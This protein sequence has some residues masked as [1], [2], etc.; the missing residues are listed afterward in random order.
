M[1]GMHSKAIEGRSMGAYSVDIPAVAFFILEWTVYSFTLEHTAYGRHS[2]SARMN[3]YREV[4]V[5]RMLDREGINRPFQDKES[6]RW[7]IDRICTH[8]RYLNRFRMHAMQHR[9]RQPPE[10]DEF[11]LKRSAASHFSLSVAGGALAGA[12]SP[13]ARKIASSL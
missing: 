12:T 4:W 7:N 11:R 13:R 3:A 9:A 2:L 5:R 1:H 8:V 10:R 6:H